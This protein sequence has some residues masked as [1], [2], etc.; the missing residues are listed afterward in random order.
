[1][2]TLIAI[3]RRRWIIVWLGLEINIV[4][5]LGWIC[6]SSRGSYRGLNTWGRDDEITI[7]PPNIEAFAKYFLVQAVGSA[8]FLVFPL[9]YRLWE[10]KGLAVIFI[11]FGL[12]IKRGVAPFHQ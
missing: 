4:G 6:I 10:M 1:L 5:F 11:L 3:S 12:F 2:G 7:F 8:F 9:V